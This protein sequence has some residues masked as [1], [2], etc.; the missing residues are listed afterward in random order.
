MNA[1]LLAIRQLGAFIPNCL[2]KMQKFM[3]N[4]EEEVIA[5]VQKLETLGWEEYGK[6]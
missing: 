1:G 5:K 3:E 6:N 4:Q 2:E